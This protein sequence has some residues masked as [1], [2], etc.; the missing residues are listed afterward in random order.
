M[1][2]TLATL[3]VGCFLAVCLTGTANAQS[4]SKA[5]KQFCAADYHKYCGEYGLESAALRVC[6]DKN[7]RSL[8]K[9]CVKA[10]IAS[11]EVS[12]AEVNRRKK[13]AR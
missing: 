7:G 5:V 10:L 12:Q 9:G 1:R 4:Y 2:T 13:A 3:G 6:M 8:S 11:G